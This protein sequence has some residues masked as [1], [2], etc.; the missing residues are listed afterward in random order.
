[1]EHYPSRLLEEAVNELSRLPGIGRRGAL[2]LALHL[3]KQDAADVNRFGNAIIRLRNNINYCTSC[4]NISESEV[5]SIC[6]NPRRDNSQIC[7]VQDIRDVMAVENTS[8][9]NGLYHVLGGI[10]SPMDGIGHGQLNIDSLVEKVNSGKISE[11]IMALSAT[12]EGDTTVFYISKKLRDSGVKISI[13]AR[14]V[15]IGG[16]L[17]YADEVTLGRSILNRVPYENVLIK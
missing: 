4:H 16:E 2:R 17:E 1:M 12:M 3:L 15:A 11:V 14:G 7:V 13:L 6:A 8:Q 10:I 5:C 9:F